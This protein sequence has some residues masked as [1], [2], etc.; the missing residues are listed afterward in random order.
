MAS[1]EIGV[2]APALHS[3]SIAMANPHIGICV[4][5]Y[6]R[7]QMLKRLLGDLIV[8]NTG[9]L[10][11]YSIV[12]AD[13]DSSESARAAVADFAA[14]SHVPIRYFVEPMQNIALARNK[15]VE[16][17]E[18][19]FIAF[20]DDDEFPAENWLLTLFKTCK[21]YDVDGV[22]GP[23]LRHFDEP[24]PKWIAKSRLYDRRV[25]PT[26][27]VVE[28]REART[29][30]VLFKK[31]IL[32][33]DEPPFRSEF[34]AGEDQDFFR[35]MIERGYVFMWSAEAVA[36]EIIPP[37]R[38]K[39]SYILRK[40]LLR[41]A[42]ASLQPDCG[43]MNIAKSMLAVPLYTMALPV[44]LVLG[45]HR[46]MTLLMKICDHLGKLLALVHLN[47]VTEE[48]VAEQSR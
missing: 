42:T 43:S 21:E 7:P 20:I 45:H 40:A 15:A 32:P 38:W 2:D 27:T 5:T 36:Y 46:F 26:G 18:G 39:R 33:A 13:N 4:C 34:R 37:A 22:L 47:P 14:A 16:N 11:T 23:V 9:G 29:G 48:Y 3:S 35:R 17:V 19:D 44:A 31:S 12:I 25:N 8:Q 41:G 28:W 6:R 24:P 30:N 1:Q 10:F